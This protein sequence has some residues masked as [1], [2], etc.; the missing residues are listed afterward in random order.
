MVLVH[1][2]LGGSAQWEAEIAHFSAQYDVIAPDLP[3]FGD[4]SG[5]SGLDRIDAMAQA[6]IRLLDGLALHEFA[7]LGHSMGGM[8][9]QEIAAMC[10]PR[11]TQL[12]LYSTGPL[13]L[14]PDRF[15]TIDVSKK[16]LYIDGVA[17]TARR[18]AATWFL[19]G[20]AGQGFDLAAELAERVSD[21]A[22][23]AALDAMADW[24]GRHALERLAVPTLILWGDSDKSYRWPQIE[25]LWKAIP[26]AR[27]AVVPGAAHAVHLEK[28]ALFHA[29]LDDF[30]S[31]Q[32]VSL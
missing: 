25:S 8:I 17:E 10:G 16:W 5:M 28:P 2:Y 7:L 9:T 14:M 18:I 12:I 29:I 15:E 6:V 31:Q 19:G 24:D 4:A 32:T 3:G 20:E 22:A 27:L 1:G 13:G 26:K 11:I 21:H 30:L 23:H